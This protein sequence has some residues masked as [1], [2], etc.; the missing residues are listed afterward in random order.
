MHPVVYP[1]KAKMTY[2]GRFNRKRKRKRKRK[3]CC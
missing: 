3:S 1:K 2:V